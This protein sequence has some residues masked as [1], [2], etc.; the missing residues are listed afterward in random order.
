MQ[1]LS[2]H[3]DDGRPLAPAAWATTNTFERAQGWLKRDAVAPGEGLLIVPC[4]SI[5][6]FGMRFAIDALFLD[7]EARVLKQVESLPPGRLAF[8]PLGRLWRPWALQCLELPAG[9]LAGLGDLR[10][11]TLRIERRDA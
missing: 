11:R 4:G 2:I 10:G 5:H 6:S 9:T 7:R 8:G 3:L 1:A